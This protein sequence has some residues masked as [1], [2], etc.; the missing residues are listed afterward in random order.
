MRKHIYVE[1][2]AFRCT[3]LLQEQ[4]QALANRVN[5]HESDLIRN[6]VAQYVA[7]Y[8]ERPEELVKV[9]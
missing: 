3:P 9:V 2:K 8:Q 1:T 5:R 4:L 7:Y 6:A